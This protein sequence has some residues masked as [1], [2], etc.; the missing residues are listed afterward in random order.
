MKVLVFSDSHGN[1]TNMFHVLE[2]HPEIEM[3]FHCGD[4]GRDVSEP[5]AIYPTRIFE[6]VRGNCDTQGAYPLQKN[7]QLAGKNILITHGH[8]YGVKY[9]LTSLIAKGIQEKLDILVFGHTHIPC[10]ERTDGLLLVNPGSISRPKSL[11]KPTYAV[12][13]LSASG[14]DASIHTV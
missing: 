4:C 13:E 2:R 1:T 14:I 12:L 8:M 6:A 11:S 9:G 10:I 3:V 5:Q 7:M